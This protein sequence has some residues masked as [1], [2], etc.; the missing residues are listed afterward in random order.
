MM[1]M[2]SLSGS[3]AGWGQCRISTLLAHRLP[4]CWMPSSGFGWGLGSNGT[5]NRC[6]EGLVCAFWGHPTKRK[7]MRAKGSLLKTAS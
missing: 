7:F 1:R 5:E 3:G 2:W 4:L 6:R